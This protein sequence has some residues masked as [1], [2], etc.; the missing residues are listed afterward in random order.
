MNIIEIN[1][2]LVGNLQ[3]FP[4]SAQAF[5]ASYQFM[6]FGNLFSAISRF[7]ILIGLPIIE[8]EYEFGESFLGF[9]EEINED[10]VIGVSFLKQVHGENTNWKQ[11]SYNS[12]TRKNF[13]GINH[14]YDEGRD[15]FIPPKPYPSWT[16]NE[17]TCIWEAP[18]PRP[19]QGTHVWNEDTQTWVD[20]TL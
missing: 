19:E 10:R 7:P 3:S 11:C 4:K 17:G 2:F 9:S 12:T 18:S 1:S 5:L 8:A 16:L 15:A 13:P 20:M 14:T 6:R